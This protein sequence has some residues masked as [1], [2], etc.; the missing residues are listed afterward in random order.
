MISSLR[1]FQ[2][3]QTAI[4]SRDES[5]GASGQRREHGIF[6]VHQRIR[7]RGV[8]IDGEQSVVGTEPVAAVVDGPSIRFDDGTDCTG[9]SSSLKFT[10]SGYTP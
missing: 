6:I 3:W 1:V 5:R 8:E 9:L 7:G 4:G 2:R 10:T